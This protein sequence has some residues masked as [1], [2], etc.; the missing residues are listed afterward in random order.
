LQARKITEENHCQS[1][2]FLPFT[3]ALP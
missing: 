1:N 2:K 3:I